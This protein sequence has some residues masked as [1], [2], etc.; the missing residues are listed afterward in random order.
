MKTL[1]KLQK[2]L[3]CVQMFL[4]Q[5]N[6][7]YKSMKTKIA[8]IWACLTLFIVTTAIIS[9]NMTRE[10]TNRSEYFQKGDTTV[11]IQTKTIETYNAEKK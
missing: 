2:T 8:K 7:N 1:K 10:V 6:K 11:T 9:C 4:N 5:I 3:K